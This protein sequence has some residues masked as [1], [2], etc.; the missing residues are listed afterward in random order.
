MLFY[1]YSEAQPLFITQPQIQLKLIFF[2]RLFYFILENKNSDKD[3]I[4]LSIENFI[5]NLTISNDKKALIVKY[6]LKIYYTKRQI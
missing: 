3:K 2:L 5:N 6:L 4:L 1:N